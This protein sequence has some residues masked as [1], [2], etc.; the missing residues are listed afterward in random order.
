VFSLESMVDLYMDHVMDDDDDTDSDSDSDDNSDIDDNDDDDDDENKKYKRTIQ[1]KKQIQSAM[2]GTT[3]FG[4]QHLTKNEFQKRLWGNTY[5]N[6]E[7]RQF[8]KK[9]S[10]SS[11]KRTF[12]TFIL[13]PLYKLYGLCLGENEK[14]MNK[15]LRTLGIHLS[16]DQMRSDVH[17]LLNI[18]MKKFFGDCRS[19]VDMVVKNV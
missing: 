5:Y 4:Q 3:I 1:Q 8:T 14:H 9:P 7:T 12:C 2:F 18:V 10:S 13:E 6:S 19:F 15:V 11:T 16:K 17:V